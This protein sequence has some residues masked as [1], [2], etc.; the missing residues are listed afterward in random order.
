LLA[1]LLAVF[2]APALA[3]GEDRAVVLSVPDAQGMEVGAKAAIVMEAKTGKVLFAQNIHEQLPIASTTKIMTALLAL[4][5]NDI[6]ALFEVDDTAIHVE[7]TSMGLVEGDKA[8]LRALATGMLLSSG[9]D[10]AGAAAVRISGSLPEFANTMNERARRIGMENTNFV[11]PSGL[12]AEGHLS[13]AYDMA[14]LAREALSN[15]DFQ[16]ICSQYRLRAS[17][18][19]PPYDRW[20]QNHNRLLSSY[21]GTYGVKTGFTR[22]AGRCLVSAARR[23]G[24]ELIC[25]TLSFPGDWAIHRNFYDKFFAEL[26]FKN[27]AEDIPEVNV[28]VVGG[29]ESGVMAVRFEEAEFSVPKEGADIRYE[30]AAPPFVYAPVL[31]GQYLGEARIYLE[32]ENV[33]TLTLTADRDV[34][35]LHAEKKHWWAS[36]VDWFG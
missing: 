12:D 19:N 13:T 28:P 14:L 16:N 17:F 33:F 34:P 4:E 30:I 18:G 11:T 8:S 23:D 27:L 36:I 26:T 15:R 20:L 25:V 31:A 6:D 10:A 32:G 35:L 1:A 5:Q 22:K 9:N 29:T 2:S 3:A 7:G 21:D 24:V